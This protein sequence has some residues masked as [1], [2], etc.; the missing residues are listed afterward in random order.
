MRKTLLLL[1]MVLTLVFLT[2]VTS[3]AQLDPLAS[4]PRVK[5]LP[6]LPPSAV[7]AS[8]KTTKLWCAAVDREGQLL[9]DKATD[10]RGTPAVPTGSDAWPGSN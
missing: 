4:L 9:L 8:G 7:R 6:A 1:G 2:S 10:T 5:R 3:R